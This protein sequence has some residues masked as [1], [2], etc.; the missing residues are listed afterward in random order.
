MLGSVVVITMKKMSMSI[1]YGVSLIFILGACISLFFS[2][3]FQFTDTEEMAVQT[4]TTILSYIVVFIGGIFCGGKGKSKG[5]LIG[6]LTGTTY[7]LIIFLF[8]YLGL[9]QLFT[10]EQALYYGCYI[11]TAMTGGVLGVNLTKK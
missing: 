3:I 10:W 7:A 4:V 11:L 5:W 6:G 1:M 2:L 8:Q 9:N